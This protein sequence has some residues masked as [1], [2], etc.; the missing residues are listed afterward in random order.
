MSFLLALVACSTTPPLTLPMENAPPLSVSAPERG[1]VLSIVPTHCHLRPGG[2]QRFHAKFEGLSRLRV[3]WRLEGEGTLENGL[4]RA[5]N[6]KA[7]ARVI[8]VAV[9][10]G[11]PIGSVGATVEVEE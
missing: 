1:H 7:V 10:E 5:P 4:Y 11:G 3:E 8:A 6:K 9:A 2:A